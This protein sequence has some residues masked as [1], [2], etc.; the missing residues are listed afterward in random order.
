MAYLRLISL[1]VAHRA[2]I[3]QTMGYRSRER[4]LRLSRNAERFPTGHATET[5]EYPSS[6][7]NRSSN[8]LMISERSGSEAGQGENDHTRLGSSL[9]RRFATGP[10]VRAH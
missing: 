8:D 3:F 5:P 2:R 9:G 10:E 7:T 4:M 1:T 6:V